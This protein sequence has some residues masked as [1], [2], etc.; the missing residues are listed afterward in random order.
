MADNG[1]S[2]RQ[3]VI[4]RIDALLA[5]EVKRAAQSLL[6]K[7][8]ARALHS[9]LF[10]DVASACRHFGLNVATNHHHVRHHVRSYQDQAIDVLPD[11][12][13]LSVPRCLCVECPCQPVVFAADGLSEE[14]EVDNAAQAAIRARLAFSVVRDMIVENIASNREISEHVLREYGFVRSMEAI[15]CDR[16]MGRM[17]LPAEGRRPV[18]SPTCER[19]VLDTMK[20][21]RANK[22][23]FFPETIDAI[24]SVVA[25]KASVVGFAFGRPWRRSFCQRHSDAIAVS[26][27]SLLEDVR[28]RCCTS[29]KV[30]RH[31]EI[32]KDTLLNLGWAD[33]NPHYDASVP[34]DHANPLNTT[35]CPIIVKQEFAGRIISM[36]E[37]RFSLNQA[38]EQK[39]GK[40][41]MCF[42][43]SEGPA[44]DWTDDRDVGLNK[45]VI[46]ASFVGGSGADARALPCMCIF[47][48]TFAPDEDLPNMPR[49]QHRRD[50]AGELLFTHGTSN[51]KGAMTDVVML[52]WLECVV[53]PSFPDL[54][55]A[56]PVL[57][58]CDG[59][60]S[61]LS[62]P[63]L[64]RA[65]VLGIVIVLR[66]P[67]TSHVT[68][69][70]DVVG[71]NFST[72]HRLE[73]V[74]KLAVKNGRELAD[75]RGRGAGF[76][77]VRA[78]IGGIV[79]DAWQEGFS[80]R[81]NATAWQRIGVFPLFNRRVY[82]SLLAEES[83]NAAA[84]D[85]VAPNRPRPNHGAQ[86]LA[87]AAVH[88]DDVARDVFPPA[89][90][91][92]ER[93][94]GSENCWHGGAVTRPQYIAH[95]EQLLAEKE[96]EVGAKRAAAAIRD[97]AAAAKQQERFA[98][99]NLIIPLL[100][101]GAMVVSALTCRQI[102]E[103]LTAL[104]QHVGSTPVN[105]QIKLAQ[106][107]N[108]MA[109]VGLVFAVPA[110][111]IAAAEIN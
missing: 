31:Y 73:R 68:Q 47:N 45:G 19:K 41:K 28:K 66:P 26:N 74:K 88:V 29:G 25:E 40:R 52:E 7:D 82:W 12:S 105:K 93:A 109:S 87:V 24:A 35:C 106:L 78:D 96:E 51:E 60:G 32:L 97:A 80:T 5:P 14:E 110:P 48:G 59:Y 101:A 94:N 42:M 76:Q 92:R 4:N 9:G 90:A 111:A 69:G 44:D 81:V 38:K 57:L 21:L 71:G 34:W 107:T 70:E 49:C 91:R 79:H 20:Y 67:H 58:I 86:D 33:V 37:T 85:A 27:P 83:K 2:K 95:R 11:Y 75:Q 39:L 17:S 99:G 61:H 18:L 55:P 104:G 102:D 23:G 98:A 103:V 62:L 100:H 64:K 1:R 54:S 8:A 63:M 30:A 65:V 50:A 46:A 36:D 53:V 108:Y 22:I 72:F 84:L 15:R 56:N 13:G 89:Q 77:L 43:K 6:R 10:V 3:C 16:H